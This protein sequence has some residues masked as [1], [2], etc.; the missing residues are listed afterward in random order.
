MNKNKRDVLKGLAVG[1]VWATPVVSSVVLPVHASTSCDGLVDV[2][3]VFTY[4]ETHTIVEC[5]PLNSKMLYSRSPR[6][7]QIV[8]I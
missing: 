2:S 6:G 5:S 4:F 8:I 7:V 3:I 1:S